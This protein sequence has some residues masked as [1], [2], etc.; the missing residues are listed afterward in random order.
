[1]RFWNLKTGRLRGTLLRFN[2]IHWLALSPEGHYRGSANIEGYFEFK[3]L[4][5]NRLRQLPYEK[6]RKFHGWKNNPE[7]VKLTG[8]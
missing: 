2:S 6:F 3:F 4:E 1:M 8:D 5:K 7:R